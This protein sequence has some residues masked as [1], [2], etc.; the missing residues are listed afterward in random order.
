M[1]RHLRSHCR[2]VLTFVFTSLALSLLPP[3]AWAKSIIPEAATNVAASAVI[4]KAALELHTPL[5]SVT[6]KTQLPAS[7]NPHDYFSFAPYWWPDPDCPEGLPYERRDGEYNQATRGDATD[8]QRLIDFTDTV[9]T[10]SW[11]Y[12]LTDDSEYAQRAV[13]QL[14]HWFITSE[15]RM[16]PNLLYAQAIPGRID[17]RGIGLIESRL[18][19]ELAQS[20]RRLEPAPAMTVETLQ[21]LKQWYSDYLDW[22]LTSKNG[23]DEH[24]KRNN[25]GTWYDAQIVAFARFVDRQALAGRQLHSASHRIATQIA[26]GGAQP[27]ELARTRPW[28]YVNFNLE[29]WSTLL[30][31]SSTLGLRWP[32]SDADRERLAAAYRWIAERAANPHAWPYRELHG[33]HPA[34][35]LPNL[36]MA[37]RHHLLDDDHRA[38]VLVNKWTRTEDLV[39]KPTSLLSLTMPDPQ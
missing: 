3:A 14:R 9:N 4:H 38:G 1:I 25:H 35:A 29:A 22:M 10:L 19:I 2:R 8:K 6:D 26:E 21:G 11:R 37:Q 5:Y 30:E 32:D 31:E 16:A 7:G 34:I 33:F 20:I 13:T 36:V 24:A 18:L 28:H 17:G 12:R 39:S 27:L 23:Q 15:T